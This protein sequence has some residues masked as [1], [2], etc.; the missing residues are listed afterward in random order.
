MYG[1]S[2]VYLLYFWCMKFYK[3]KFCYRAPDLVRLDYPEF[4]EA[5]NFVPQVGVW[6]VRKSGDAGHGK[7]NRQVILHQPVDWCVNRI[8]INIGGNSS[9]YVII[10]L[11]SGSV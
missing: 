10:M 7:V 2:I 6:E 9:W 1:V 4:S 3:M 5:A 8:P 11:L